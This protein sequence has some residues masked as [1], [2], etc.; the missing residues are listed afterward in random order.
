MRFDV[1]KFGQFA[2]TTACICSKFCRI[3][4]GDSYLLINMTVGYYN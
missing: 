4:H 3:F 1:E 2:L